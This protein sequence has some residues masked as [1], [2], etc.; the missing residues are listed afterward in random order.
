MFNEARLG[1][2]IDAEHC[3][4]LVEEISASVDRNP[5][6]L[7]SL[8]RLKTRRRI[9][10]HAFG[11]GVRA[12]GGARP[13]N[14]G[15]TTT[16]CREAGLAGLLHD[17]GKAAMP[18][19]ILKKP[20]KLTDEEFDLMRS[21]PAARPRDAAGRQARPDACSTCACTTTS[22]ST[23]WATPTGCRGDAL[24]LHARM[25]AVCDV[26]DAITSNRPYK[27]GW[28]PAESVA[29]MAS[30]QGHFDEPVLQSFVRSLGIYPTGS[31]VRM[32]SGRLAVVIEQTRGSLVK[33]VVKV[34]FSTRSNMPVPVQTL[35]LSNPNATDRIAAREPVGAWNFPQL[36][37]LWAGDAAPH[38]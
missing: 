35:D 4:P 28:D 30:W 33:P 7:I 20:G 38:R 25:G 21:H 2:A 34:F 18:P 8:A 17:M 24:S 6:A 1:N 12:D 23:A 29:K 31:L 16:A 14:W 22:A 15:W 9:H 19:E 36:N 27:A 11:G 13:R 32:H 37:A 3:L 5:G 26:Y 10:L